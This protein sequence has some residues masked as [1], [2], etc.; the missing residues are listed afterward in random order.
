[1][2]QFKGVLYRQ[3][4]IKRKLDILQYKKKCHLLANRGENGVL[5]TRIELPLFVCLANMA[6]GN[7]TYPV[8]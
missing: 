6:Y 3:Y 8:K 7:P 1:M 2:T 5:T 4:K